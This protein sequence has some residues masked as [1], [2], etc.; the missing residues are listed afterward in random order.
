MQTFARLGR[1][2]GIGPGED[3]GEDRPAASET[4]AIDSRPRYMH[5]IAPASPR[6][7]RTRSDVA[8]SYGF[9]TWL[10]PVMKA[11]NSALWLAT[12]SAGP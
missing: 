4:R 8:A 11:T 7:N 12:T 9:G 6:R 2:D 10:I 5:E 1:W 3:R